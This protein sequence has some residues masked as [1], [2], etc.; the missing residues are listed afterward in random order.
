MSYAFPSV[1]WYGDSNSRRTLRPF[2]VG[3]KWCHENTTN[4]RLDCLCNDAPKDL[5]PADW[6]HAMPN[7]HWYRVR[8]QGV[9]LSMLNTDLRLV[10]EPPTDPRPIPEKDPVDDDPGCNPDYMPPGYSNRRDYFDLY[11]LFTRGTNDMHGSYWDRDITTARVSQYPRPQLV[12]FQMVTWDA[13]YS[14]FADFVAETARLVIRLKSVYPKAQFI[15][16]SGPL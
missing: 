4:T 3:G 12:V 10:Q 5:F 14:S 2:M 6:Y 8:G 15:Y 13:A 7:P 9:D 16:R 11:Y 1:H